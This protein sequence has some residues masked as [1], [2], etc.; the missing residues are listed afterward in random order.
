[1]TV[2]ETAARLSRGELVSIAGQEGVKTYLAGV[3]KQVVETVD[4]AL[5]VNGSVLPVHQLVLMSSSALFRD[6]LSSQAS[7][8]QG[9][10][11]MQGSEVQVVPLIDDAQDCVQDA[12]A[13]M[14]QHISM[15]SNKTPE[16]TSILAAKHLVMFGHK[17]GVQALLDEGDAFISKWCKTKLSRPQDINTSASERAAQEVVE[18]I[19]EGTG[20]CLTL[21]ACELWF[22]RYIWDLAGH[23]HGLSGILA[24]MSSGVLA[25]IMSAVATKD[26]A[27]V[28]FFTPI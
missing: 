23:L 14:Y 19:A 3:P 5:L 22:V 11:G 8:A 9:M 21:E 6:L 20:L 27:F 18:W 28:D 1:M 12:L 2:V 17:Y 10:Q 15:L 25:R 24:Q 4:T 7:T 16:V 26:R 13:Y